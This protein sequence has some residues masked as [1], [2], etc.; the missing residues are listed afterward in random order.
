MTNHGDVDKVL[1]AIASGEAHSATPVDNFYEGWGLPIF[2]WGS[3]HWMKRD[4]NGLCQAHCG[5]I[6][7]INPRSVMDARLWKRKCKICLK[8]HKPDTS[9]V[10]GPFKGW[11]I[12]TPVEVDP[13][14]VD[15][16][17]A[18]T[19][20]RERFVKDNAGNMTEDQWGNWVNALPEAEFFA[21]MSIKE[22]QGKK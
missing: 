17:V 18:M 5:R 8:D 9:T 11:P 13:T 1:A 22:P 12:G 3:A 7:N 14:Q 6:A 19:S 21:M 4:D 10:C 2:S 16:A 15:K 20:F